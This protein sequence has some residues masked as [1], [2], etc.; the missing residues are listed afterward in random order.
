MQTQ[1]I[2]IF[3]HARYSEPRVVIGIT[4]TSLFCSQGMATTSAKQSLAALTPHKLFI[5]SPGIADLFTRF[6]SPFEHS[7]FS[8]TSRRESGTRSSC[9]ATTTLASPIHRAE[10]TLQGQVQGGARGW[11]YSCS[12]N[13]LGQSPAEIAPNSTTTSRHQW[14]PRSFIFGS[15]SLKDVGFCRR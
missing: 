10:A 5:V 14:E 13:A 8:W 4:A 1:N 2:A 12:V 3:L 11:R 9:L 6:P 7:L 15:P